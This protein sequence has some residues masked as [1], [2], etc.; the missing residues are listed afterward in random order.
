MGA[1]V[2]LMAGLGGAA[3]WCAVVLVRRGRRGSTE[4]ADGL[5][6][7]QAARLR[8]QQMKTDGRAFRSHPH[9]ERGSGQRRH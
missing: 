8:A 7:E 9:G 4:N 1:F 2:A 6:I 5:L 3:A